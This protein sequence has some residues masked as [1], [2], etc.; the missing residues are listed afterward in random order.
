M[1]D[2]IEIDALRVQVTIGQFVWLCKPPV[3]GSHQ[4]NVDNSGC[5]AFHGLDIASIC[6]EPQSGDIRFEIEMARE[7]RLQ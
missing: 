5:T 1:I 4:N 2:S 3:I 6:V 7:Q